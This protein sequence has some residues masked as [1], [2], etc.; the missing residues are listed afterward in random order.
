MFDLNR[1]LDLENLSVAD[2]AMLGDLQVNILK[3][4]GRPF[5]KLLFISFNSNQKDKARIFVNNIGAL[6]TSAKKQL[7]DTAFFKSTHLPTDAVLAFYL[8]HKGY[9]AI[10]HSNLSPNHQPYRDGLK[11]RGAILNDPPSAKWNAHLRKEIHALV[12]IGGALDNPKKSWTSKQAAAKESIVRSLLK[13]CGTVIGTETGRS[14]HNDDGNGLEH[15]GYVDGRSQP[16]FTKQDIDSERANMRPVTANFMWDPTFKLDRLMVPDSGGTGPHSM[17]SFFVMRKLEQNVKKFKA[18]EA[19]LQKRLANTMATGTLKKE[20]AGSMIVGRFENG[21]PITLHDAEMRPGANVA[22]NFNYAND[23]SGAKCPFHSHIRKTNPRNPDAG[24]RAHIMARRGIT[25]GKR[26]LMPKG[27]LNTN[28]EPTKGVGLLFMAYNVNISEQFE[29]TQSK[30]ANNT[31]FPNG[32]VGPDAIIG[33]GNPAPQ[34]HPSRWDIN[35]CPIETSHFADCVSMRGGE[36]FFAP[37]RS[38]LQTA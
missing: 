7:E 18:A 5:V 30:W 37:S 29:F 32:G 25:Y 20:V 26:K 13:P 34:H 14:I 10:G 27:D 33:L 4:H 31:N 38:F 17:G 36:Y 22:N 19:A 2:Q 11:A 28:D 6:V 8:T 16:L 24:E 35:G 23:A 15:F 3:G 21:T 12:L 1:T 9:E